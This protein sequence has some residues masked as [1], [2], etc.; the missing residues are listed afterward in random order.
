MIKIDTTNFERAITIWMKKRIIIICITI[1]MNGKGG[2]SEEDNSDVELLEEKSP[3]AVAFFVS[4]ALSAIL[5][6]HALTSIQQKNTTNLLEDGLLE[7]IEFIHA[8]RT[9]IPTQYL[10]LYPLSFVN[11]PVL[12]S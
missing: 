4:M 7:S 9:I 11:R 2:E 5:V 3:S 10:S 6:L 8:R 1:A 12:I